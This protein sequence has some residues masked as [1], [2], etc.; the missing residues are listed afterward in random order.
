MSVDNDVKSG[1]VD[2]SRFDRQGEPALGEGV[3]GPVVRE[4]EQAP[5]G[6]VQGQDGVRGFLLVHDRTIEIGQGGRA[7]RGVLFAAG[8]ENLR[9]PA[10]KG[11]PIWFQ[12]DRPRE[13]LDG[14]FDLVL[15][16]IDMRQLGIR[17]E[18]VFVELDRFL[19]VGRGLLELIALEPDQTAVDE[20]DVLE[21]AVRRD[22]E[23]FE[24]FLEIFLGFVELEVSRVFQGFLSPRIRGNEFQVC[25]RRAARW[26]IRGADKA[27]RNCGRCR[28]NR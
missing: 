13:L 12:R 20:Q 15:F 21:L 11:R 7:A 14:L 4:Q 18:P 16:L 27:R 3:F 24:R 25:A 26:R 17:L 2:N 28:C 1:R 19:I 6:M 10:I 5:I 9:S 8:G 23:P 22:C